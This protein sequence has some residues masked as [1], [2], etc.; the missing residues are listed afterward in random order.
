MHTHLSISLPTFG[1]PNP[2][3]PFIGNEALKRFDMRI[4]HPM[5]NGICV[6]WEIWEK[7]VYSLWDIAALNENP[8]LL[9]QSSHN[10]MNNKAKAIQ[11]LFET[12]D[13]PLMMLVSSDACCLFANS[14]TNGVSWD[15]GYGM[16]RVVPVYEG[17]VLHDNIKQFNVS[18]K[19]LTEQT[20][21]KLGIGDY[22][23]HFNVAED[24]K[25]KHLCVS[26][27]GFECKKEILCFS[28]IS[29]SLY[30]PSFVGEARMISSQYART[31][32]LVPSIS[33]PCCER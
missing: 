26:L 32:I 9:T 23:Q 29:R 13:V 27:D 24:I 8:F 31:E 6:D 28:Q 20:L 22:K 14:K 17:H 3:G 25:K 2:H 18:G 11:I 10:L 1:C 5:E 15:A 30:R 12:M 4:T 21:N 19:C 7:M 33:I 16:S